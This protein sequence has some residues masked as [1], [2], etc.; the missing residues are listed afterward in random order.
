MLKCHNQPRSSFVPQP[1][2]T[3]P[4]V[5]RGVSG[6][7]NGKTHLHLP[8]LTSLASS[9]L[10]CKGQ[11]QIE[12]LL[13][14][15]GDHVPVILHP[16]F[17]SRLKAKF[18]SDPGLEIGKLNRRSNHDIPDIVWSMDLRSEPLHI[19]PSRVRPSGVPCW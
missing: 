12:V 11:E 10:P 15:H 3:S 1:K 7:N 6:E 9:N 13:I 18:L 2:P 17:E 5:Y 19:W 16:Q 4:L 14:N 8:H